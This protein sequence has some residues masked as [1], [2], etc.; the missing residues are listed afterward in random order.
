[1]VR[2]GHGNTNVKSVKKPHERQIYQ[3]TCKQ[4]R[5]HARTVLNISDYVGKKISPI[6]IHLRKKK[7]HD[8]MKKKCTAGIGATGTPLEKWWTLHNQT[9][10]SNAIFSI[11]YYVYASAKLINSQIR[12]NNLVDVLMFSFSIFLT[13]YGYVLYND[14]DRTH[15]EI[16]LTNPKTGQRPQ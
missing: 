10:R 2:E 4:V 7:I 9:D 11:Q 14:K 1:M 15:L 8:I 13:V 5:Y 3:S 12:S 6:P 16:Y